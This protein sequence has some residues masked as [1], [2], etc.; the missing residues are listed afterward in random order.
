MVFPG[1]FGK[2]EKT[3]FTLLQVIV[4][5]PACAHAAGASSANRAKT[6]GTTARALNKPRVAPRLSVHVPVSW[7]RTFM[8]TSQLGELALGYPE[9]VT[10]TPVDLHN[11][12]PTLIHF[13]CLQ[14]TTESRGG[15]GGS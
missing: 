7:S 11:A 9:P 8:V 6:I 4:A 14:Q 12:I 10:T 3:Y 15:V 1:L 5:E 13:L 2:S